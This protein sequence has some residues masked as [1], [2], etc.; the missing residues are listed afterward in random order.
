MEVKIPILH[1]V[2]FEFEKGNI[3]IRRPDGEFFIQTPERRY[4]QYNKKTGKY[5]TEV[6]N[7]GFNVARVYLRSTEGVIRVERS[8]VSGELIKP[9]APPPP[10]PKPPAATPLP[11]A[12]PQAPSGVAV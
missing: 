7:F 5:D 11:P 3:I 9:V 1:Y 2:M 12:K 4:D 8:F 10:A 6:P